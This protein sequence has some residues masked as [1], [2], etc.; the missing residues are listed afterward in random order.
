MPAKGDIIMGIFAGAAIPILAH[1]ISNFVLHRMRLY[2]ARTVWNE[3]L[4]Q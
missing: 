4:A 3:V 1:P 2:R